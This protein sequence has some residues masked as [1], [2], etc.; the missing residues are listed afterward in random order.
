MKQLQ[1]EQFGVLGE[2]MAPFSH[3]LVVPSILEGLAPAMVWVDD[4]A[5]PGAAVVWDLVNGLVFC[6]VRAQDAA[7][8][9][10]LVEFLRDDLVERAEAKGYV[11]FQLE[12][13]P[14]SV[15]E[16]VRDALCDK[17]SSNESLLFY[18]RSPEDGPVTV[19]VPTEEVGSFD[20]VQL[21]EE[22]LMSDLENMDEIRLCVD[23]CWRDRAR[24]LES[25]IGYCAV[26]EGV[27]SAWCST[28]YLVGGS[29]DLYVETFEPYGRRGL[30]VWVA[31][32]CISACLQ[33]GYQVHWHCWSHNT[34]SRLV[35]ER[36]GLSLVGAR[37]A[38]Q[39]GAEGESE[40]AEEV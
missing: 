6:S 15:L 25:G 7:A 9:E 1:K 2:L 13:D 31:T 17:P 30:G 11:P 22:L 36:S 23:A 20:V 40:G 14:D 35:A 38:L 37:S 33:A 5:S 39:I 18:S 24:Y 32:S 27:A 34:G 19:I 28:D 26:R 16:E 29:A 12:A 8:S 21:T 10:S 3:Q 4:P